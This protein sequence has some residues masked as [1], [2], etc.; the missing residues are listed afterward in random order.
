MSVKPMAGFDMDNRDPNNIN[1]HLQ[2][3]WDDVIGEPEGIRST[4]CAWNC[5]YKCF[6]GTKNCCY[7]LLATIF[8]PC[9]AFC[10]AI[11][12]A[13]LAFQHIW[14]MTPCL[15]TWKINCAFVRTCMTIGLAAT[16]GPCAEI[17]GLYFSKVRVRYQRMPDAGGED[18]DVF[19]V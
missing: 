9:L 2:V 17:C 19:T 4:E 1:E 12:F 13:C 3:M 14:C 6:R 10:S 5:S 11:N 16:C 7:L 18:K 15:R 8:A